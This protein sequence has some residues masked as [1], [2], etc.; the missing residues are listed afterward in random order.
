MAHAILRVKVLKVRDKGALSG[1]GTHH[2]GE[3]AKQEDCL[4]CPAKDERVSRNDDTL[5]LTLL[6]LH[7]LAHRFDK[8]AEGHEDPRESARALV[9]RGPSVWKAVKVGQSVPMYPISETSTAVTNSDGWLWSEVNGLR[10]V[11]VPGS[12]KYV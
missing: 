4:I 5:V 12:I 8:H 3:L 2:L 9:T 10:L 11:C 1:P 7:T 6:A